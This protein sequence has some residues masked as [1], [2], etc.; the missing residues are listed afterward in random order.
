MGVP[1]DEAVELEGARVHPLRFGTEALP[2]PVPGMSDVMPY[3]STRFSSMSEADLGAYRAAWDRHLAPVLDAFRPDVIHAH[4]LWIAASRARRLAPDVPMV[5]HSHATGLRQ[6][7]LCP[8][9]AGEVSTALGAV[10]RILALGEAHAEDVVA[11][12]GV[13][14]DRVTV[15]GAGYRD[16]LFRRTDEPR[17]PRDLLYVGKLARAK[18]LPWLLDAIEGLDVRLH[19]AGSGAGPEAE[20]LI[21]RM[22]GMGERVVRHGQVDQARL[23]ELMRRAA[24]FV[25]PSFYEGLPLVVVEAVA[26]GCRAVV[27][28]LPVVRRTLTPS[29]GD[30]I[31]PVGLPR[32]R[33]RDE[34]VTEDLPAFVRDLG[35]G[36]QAALAAKAPSTAG[37][38]LR[39]FTWDAVYERVEAVWRSLETVG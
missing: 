19:V 6:M 36:I 5:V 23:A 3:V 11:T 8:H 2:F 4:H 33:G 12:L 17:E 38:D 34:P 20:A 22:D 37:I 15:V 16:D 21:R 10:D 35:D 39:A 26:S 27:T 32:L 13:A 1:R 9:L 30:A 7:A 29:L 28:D 25:L 31:V 24:V 14:P 18:G